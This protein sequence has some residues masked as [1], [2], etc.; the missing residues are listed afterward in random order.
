MMNDLNDKRIY[1]LASSVKLQ[2]PVV[3]VCFVM[4]VQTTKSVRSA[5][6]NVR[7]V[8]TNSSGTANLNT[9]MIVKRIST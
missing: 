2:Y 9:I 3:N 4:L 7:L 5:M 6:L 8:F 1:I